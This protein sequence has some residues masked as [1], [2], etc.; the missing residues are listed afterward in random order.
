M[1]ARKAVQGLSAKEYAA[2]RRAVLDAVAP[3]SALLLPAGRELLHNGDTHYPFRQ[4]SDFLYLTGFQ[5][6]DAILV[7]LP[8]RGAG[9]TVLFCRDHDARRE[10]YDG[11]RLGPEQAAEALGLDD[12]FPLSDIDDI[13]PGLLED[14]SQIYLPLGSDEVFEG[15]LQGWIDDCRSRRGEPRS[16]P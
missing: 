8:G 6:A 9:E 5:E 4:S 13:L 3:Q 15:Q 10:R 16:G 1:T 11:P 7:L 2:R 12:A 14:R